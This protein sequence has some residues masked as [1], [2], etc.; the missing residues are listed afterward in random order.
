MLEGVIFDV[1]G[2]LVASP[3]ERAW[4][5]ALEALMAGEW[6]PLAWSTS[7]A[8]E[9]F[10][11]AVYQEYVAGKPRLSGAIAALQYFGIPTGDGRAELYAE[12]KQRLLLDL[13]EQG[14]FDAFA[15]ALRCVRRIRTRGMRLGVASSSKN[16]NQLMSKVPVADITGCVTLL[17][18]FDA[19][20]CG[21]DLPAGK[22]DPAIFLLAASALGLAPA[23]CV[24]VED[25]PSGIQAAKAGGMLAIGVARF[26]DAVLLRAAGADL[27]VPTLDEIDVDALGEGRVARLSTLSAG[28]EQT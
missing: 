20:V 18:V 9:R 16:A 26:D 24:V 19:N 13:V 7:Y 6:Q 21:R 17:D 15:D 10:S 23:A 12:R 11:T 8:P 25:A 27:V 14:K 3:H 22:P 1:D 4:Q 5:A 2:V 28:G